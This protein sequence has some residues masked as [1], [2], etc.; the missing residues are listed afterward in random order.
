MQIG[1]FAVVICDE[2]GH[3]I[4]RYDKGGTGG[5]PGLGQK[6]CIEDVDYVV[7]DVRHVDDEDRGGSFSYPKVYVRRLD[8]GALHRREPD[9]DRGTVV[10]P[11]SPPHG[12]S[13]IFPPSVLATLIVAGYSEQKIAFESSRRHVARIIRCGG[14]WTLIEPRDLRLLSRRAKRYMLEAVFFF[15]TD[16]EATWLSSM[17]EQ[18]ELRLAEAAEPDQPTNGPGSAP[19]PVSRRPIL[20]LV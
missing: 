6:V 20:R 12:A 19:Q 17:A 11:F 16:A 18:A 2:D 7:V 10:L 1:G 14:R 9:P 3:E 13:T 8:A 15:L 5:F 4:G